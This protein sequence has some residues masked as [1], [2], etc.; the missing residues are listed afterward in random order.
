MAILKMGRF[1]SIKDKFVFYNPN[2]PGIF[3][4]LDFLCIVPRKR[5]P[6]CR[7]MKVFFYG[8]TVSKNCLLF[9]ENVIL[10]GYEQ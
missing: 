8:L 6:V 3:C 9:C 5:N 4:T 2:I 1:P 7:R 10:C